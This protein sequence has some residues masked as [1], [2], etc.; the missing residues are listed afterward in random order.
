V[1]D[2]SEQAILRFAEGIKDTDS[3]REKHSKIFEIAFNSKTKWQLSIH[4]KGNKKTLVL[5]GAPEIILKFCTSFYAGER[6]QHINDE[7]RV[8]YDKMYTKFG[9]SGERVLGFASLDISNDGIE[10]YSIKTKNY[11]LEGL[12]FNG[13]ISMMDPPKVGVQ[14]AILTCKKAGVKVFMVTGDHPFT[15]EAIAKKVC[16]L[17]NEKTREQLALE[18]GVRIDQIDSKLAGAAVIYGP[19]MLNFT[20]EDWD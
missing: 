8:G 13:L 20:K 9:K 10:E 1:G 11:P 19:D 14:Q 6:I 17:E 16:I 15:A 4:K 12:V 5:K 2:P 3:F 7:F 18:Q